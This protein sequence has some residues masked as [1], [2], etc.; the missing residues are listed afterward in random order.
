MFS[1]ELGTVSGIYIAPDM[2]APMESVKDIVAIKDKG[3]VGDR[4]AKG[5]GSFQQKHA[6]ARIHPERRD[7]IRDV[8]LITQS[9]I[10]TANDARAFD[11]ELAFYAEELG[12]DPA[13][14]T[15][16]Y[17]RRNLVLAG[18]SPLELM[19]LI[20]NDFWVGSVKLRGVEEC[21]PCDRPTV[22]A[23]K[24]G[25]EQQPD[26]PVDLRTK[27]KSLFTPE[28]HGGIRA[29]VVETGHILVGCS[30]RESW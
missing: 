8:T 6:Y 3:L 26:G 24:L 15:A 17:A 18:M 27:F 14:I 4:N 19:D 13:L 2:G 11:A 28:G 9:G 23:R 29:S 21:T 22:I 12:V 16:K 1:K 20:G 10:D 7:V 25:L 30:V 5:L